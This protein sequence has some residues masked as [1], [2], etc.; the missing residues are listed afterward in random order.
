MI[1]QAQSVTGESVDEQNTM[2]D[3]RSRAAIY[4]LLAR[5][6][7]AEVDREFLQLLRTD[8]KE[9]LLE[10]GIELDSELLEGSVESVLDV[11]AEEYTGL[12]VAPG[13]VSP[14]LSVFETGM[15][16]KEASDQVTAAYR[17]AGLEYAPQH[18]GEF[19][20]HIG[21]MLA[22]VGHLLRAQA[23][24]ME[25]GQLQETRRL[26]KLEKSFLIGTLG[27]WAPGWCQRAAKVALHPFYRQV[28]GL[29]GQLLW[30]DLAT[31][32]DR[33]QL[34]QLQQANHQEPKKLD[35]DA[36]FRKASGI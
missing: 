33:K 30:S 9:P 16:Y 10:F 28:I 18:S 4:Q 19:P 12:L 6:L 7:E 13:G 15:M 31:M 21:T 23:T 27:P 36:D 34:Q 11:L 2:E 25:Q 3:L 32:A 35:Y 17:A 22:F 8:L 26:Q 20:D 5:F 1:E 14:Y 29:T 24:A